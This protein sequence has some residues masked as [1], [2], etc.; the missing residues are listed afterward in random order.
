VKKIIVL[1]CFFW[2][3]ENV[4]AQL[5]TL[6][7]FVAPE[8]AQSHGDR[9]IVFRFATLTTP[10]TITISQPANPNFPVQIINIGANSAQSLDLTPWI[11]IVENK[12]ANSILNYGFRIKST[13]PIMA[14][15]EVVTSCNCNPDIFT[16]KGKNALGTSFIIAAQTFLNN[17]NYARSG[18]DIVATQNNTSITIVPSSDI[19]GH[20][21]GVPFIIVLNQ[22]ETYSAEAV[23]TSGALHLSGSTILS[24]KPIA[25][26]LKDDSMSGGP[27]GGCADLMGDQTIPVPVTGK[28]YITLKGYLNG[29]DKVYIVATQNNTQLSIDGTNVANLNA[30]GLYVHTQT[31]PSAFIQ[32]DKPIYVLHTTGFGCEVGGAVVPPIVCTGSNTV[33]F[34]RS[35]SEFFAMN[36]LVPTGG[37]N[38]FTLNGSAANIGPGIFQ[39][40]PGTAGAWKYAQID[41]SSFIGVLQASR[42]EN[43]S[44]KFHLGV[45]HGGASSGCR[46]GYFS[47]FAAYKYE[48]S[49]IND[50][51]C[52]G[53]TLLLT[54]DSLPGATYT[55]TGP[56]GITTNGTTL[57]LLGV[58]PAQS[59]NY[60]VSGFTL[61]ACELIP[62][63]VAINIISTPLLPSIISNTPLCLGDTLIAY[64]P[65]NSSL[66]FNWNFNNGT[67]FQNDSILVPNLAPG[68]YLIELSSN[69]G[70]CISP[71]AVDSITVFLAPTID[72]IGAVD[73]CGSI[74]GFSS[75]YNID[76]EDG[77]SVIS[78]S[79][80]NTQ[81]GNG[82][83]LNTISSSNGAYYIGNYVV[84]LTTLNNCTAVDSFQVTFNPFPVPIWNVL[85]QCD[86]ETALFNSAINW[87]SQAPPNSNVIYN[88]NWGDGQ[89]SNQ[90]AASHPYDTTGNYVATITLTSTAGCIS[91]DT[92]QFTITAVPQ[93]LPQVNPQCGQTASFTVS[94]SNGNY[95]YDQLYWSIPGVGDYFNPIFDET[96]VNPGDYTATLY[97]EGTN[98]CDYNTQIA[99]TI[100]PSVTIDNLVIPN[101]ITPNDDQINDELLLE[102]LFKDCT[103]FELIILNRWGNIV[104]EM[105]N[106]SVPFKGN[107]MSGKELEQGIYFYKLTTNDGKVASGHLTLIR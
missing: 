22:G 78:W 32:A 76:P 47:D 38:S 45:I 17:A 16:L 89:T 88:I 69:L 74:T 72:Y 48:I 93:M 107:D 46:Y 95:V 12:P 56:L 7:W 52:S 2:L 24:T 79:E 101:V 20:V 91:S 53:D 64:T 29:P 63:T 58:V 30:L 49:A 9:P 60:I 35:T 19:Q 61:G 15:Y 26:T 27:Y 80:G 86:G 51:L 10:A 97:L 82:V 103:N 31:N 54:T 6:F 99:F 39:P 73:T 104:Y 84:N 34:V 4:S 94:F 25:V 70:A 43:P 71:T 50:L 36:I 102:N 42:V 83:N 1:I 55:W 85:P 33:A 57:Q 81:L 96:F 13:A 59:G 23:N 40:V 90:N 75:A 44:S 3:T 11:D 92:V 106:S 87:N 41:G 68:S 98:N 62:D 14:Y 77:V 105:D 100:L 37:E 8:I 5:D 66:T 21:A 65:G 67:L 28:E 18:F